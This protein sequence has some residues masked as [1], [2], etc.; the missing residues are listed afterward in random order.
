MRK[1]KIVSFSVVILLITV[2]FAAAVPAAAQTDTM[3]F[4]Y[5]AQHTGDYSPVAGPVQPNNQLK[6]KYTTGDVV[7]SSPAVVNGVVY[8]GSIDGNVYALDATTGAKVWSYKTDGYVQSSPAVVNGVVYVGSYDANV[9]ALNATTGAKVW[10]YKTGGYVQCSPAVSNGVVYVGNDEYHLLALNATTGAKVWSYFTGSADVDSSPAIVNGVVYLGS[11]VLNEESKIITGHVN[12]LD[13]TTGE[14]MWDCKIR[15]APIRANSPAVANGVVYIGT[16]N[17]G[18][19]AIN[20]ADGTILWNFASSG[21][22][23]YPAYANGVVYVGGGGLANHDL[24]AV[25][26]TTGTKLW[27]Y[28]T[29]GVVDSAPAVV[30]GVVYVGSR[31]GNVY[32]I[33]NESVSTPTTLTAAVSTATAYVNQHFT[34]NGTLTHMNGTP[35]ANATITLQK[36]VSGT[37]TNVV[38]GTNTTTSNGVY[39]ISTSEAAAGTF[40]YRTTYAGNATYANATSSSVSVTV[41]GIPTPT[42]TPTPSPTP[43]VTP[44]VKP[45]PFGPTIPCN[46]SCPAVACADVCGAYA[47]VASCGA[48]TATASPASFLTLPSSAP[49]SPIPGVPEFPL[50]M[51]GA[52][53]VAVALAGIYAVMRRRL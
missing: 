31:D 2:V 26:A 1:Y 45:S 14:E 5:N 10:S 13:A 17:G 7:D 52:G 44:T 51:A 39:S 25:N 19:Y 43:T 18:L 9:Y 4:R 40:Q 23:L 8:V 37:W 20:A 22:H 33:G 30:N 47:P 34:I 27:S 36:K 24:Y 42:P 6:W 50:A 38:G 3:Q 21:S 48:H 11:Y 12:A 32:A 35:I 53:V 15:D 46:V 41:N 16:T 29:G 49:L 28:T